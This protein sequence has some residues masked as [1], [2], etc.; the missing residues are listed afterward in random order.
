MSKDVVGGGGGRGADSMTT[1]AH[2]YP[3]DILRLFKPYHTYPYY[4]QLRENND[5]NTAWAD[6]LNELEIPADEKQKL[7]DIGALFKETY[8]RGDTS[9]HGR[10]SANYVIKP[11]VVSVSITDNGREQHTV[12]IG[13]DIK[14]SLNIDGLT[15]LVTGSR[16]FLNEQDQSA[17]QQ[18]LTPHSAAWV[19]CESK[20]RSVDQ[21]RFPVGV[22]ELSPRTEEETDK[23]Q[24]HYQNI[25]SAELPIYVGTYD[26]GCFINTDAQETYSG[27]FKSSFD[28]LNNLINLSLELISLE[29]TVIFQCAEG[30]DR[31]M[32]CAVIFCFVEKLY[33]DTSWVPT[34]SD[35]SDLAHQLRCNN[36]LLSSL[37]HVA[38]LMFGLC[39]KNL[40]E[41]ETTEVSSFLA[42]SGAKNLGQARDYLSIP[43]FANK[44]PIFQRGIDR[45]VHQVRNNPRI[46]Q[47]RRILLLAE[48][49]VLSGQIS[50][51]RTQLKLPR[52]D[53]T[54]EEKK[55]DSDS[56]ADDPDSLT[57]IHQGLK[58]EYRTLNDLHNLNETRRKSVET[59]NSLLLNLG[60]ETRPFL[61]APIRPSNSSTETWL[62]EQI[63][64]LTLL[65]DALTKLH[66]AHST[67]NTA[68]HDLGY[69]AY[70]LALPEL[71]AGTTLP[72]LPDF[73]DEQSTNIN[74][75]LP[76][77]QNLATSYKDAQ[78]IREQLGETEVMLLTMEN[79]PKNLQHSDSP[80]L[81]VA[82]MLGWIAG[83]R[84]Q[85]TSDLQR[86]RQNLA[87][88]RRTEG[89]WNFL[90]ILLSIPLLPALLVQLCRKCGKTKKMWDGKGLDV[91]DTLF[92]KAA[93]PNQ[94]KDDES[95]S[96]HQPRDPE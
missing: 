96:Q 3:A 65:K 20:P 10:S 55:T 29:R 11:T 30:K 67:F 89:C 95:I 9:L 37:D 72:S 7:H 51:L 71:P 17:I 38:F 25:G 68:F 26:D 87:A 44:N 39:C 88:K 40:S 77:L 49:Q 23:T 54:R 79:L 36:T 93:I 81:W 86:L 21:R 48:I 35:F 84:D 46:Q 22:L 82:D 1:T 90:A 19:D 85:L 33:R 69:S 32:A 52:P 16:H 70:S 31:S 80:A 50:E 62:N 42:T 91:W 5:H 64:Q 43:L 27:W 2:Q 57:T 34:V 76:S 66:T 15:V 14:H 60:H 6:L 41:K 4:A 61:F 45:F 74:L 18:F 78:L 75:I 83:T 92:G 63:T 53:D 24:Y 12:G 73:F 28:Q 94:Q 56:I 13:S 58:D 8:G 47:T 59:I